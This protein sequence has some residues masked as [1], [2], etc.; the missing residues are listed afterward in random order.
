MVDLTNRAAK[1]RNKLNSYDDAI[2]T[3]SGTVLEKSFAPF[4]KERAKHDSHP[5]VIYL[6]YAFN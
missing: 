2:T 6:L 5:C 3:I 4:P 1:L